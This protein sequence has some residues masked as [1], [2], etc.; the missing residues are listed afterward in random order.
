M[1]NVIEMNWWSEY[2]FKQ[3]FIFNRLIVKIFLKCVNQN[4]WKDIIRNLI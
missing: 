4:K 1:R 2:K 3:I